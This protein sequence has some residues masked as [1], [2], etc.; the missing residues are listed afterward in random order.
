MCPGVIR[1]NPGVGHPAT[2]QPPSS[3]FCSKPFNPVQR[4][5]RRKLLEKQGVSVDFC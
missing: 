2:I 5:Y 1:P 3:H 4:K